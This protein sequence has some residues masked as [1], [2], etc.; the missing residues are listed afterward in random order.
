MAFS[1]TTKVK[2]LLANEETAKIIMEYLPGIDT[3]PQAKVAH[4]MSLKALCAFPQSHIT[5]DQLEEMGK[6]LEAIAE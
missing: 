3:D 6:K 5:K 1:V 4:N 2:D